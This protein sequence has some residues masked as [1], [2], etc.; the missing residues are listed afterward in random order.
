MCVIPS[1]WGCEGGLEGAGQEGEKEVGG[2]TGAQ[3]T[4]VHRGTSNII[5]I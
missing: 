3:A 4:K 2:E 1:G 5:I